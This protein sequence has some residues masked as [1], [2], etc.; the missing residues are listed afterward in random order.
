MD[1]SVSGWQR[2]Q[3]SQV[4]SVVSDWQHCQVDRSVNFH[5]LTVWCQVDT[6]ERASAPSLTQ[7]F[8]IL[9]SRLLTPSL[10]CHDYLTVMPAL[11]S[12]IIILISSNFLPNV[13]QLSSSF[14]KISYQM[15]TNYHPQSVFVKFPTKCSEPFSSSL[16]VNLK[17][18]ERLGSIQGVT[19]HS[20]FSMPWLN[21]TVNAPS[22]ILSQPLCPS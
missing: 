16:K 1:F 10:A 11:G 22:S 13:N 18:V 3:L 9:H 14:C 20:I 12:P 4:N 5:R 19:V 7:A 6:P 21:L 17:Y 2:C 15:F 8:L